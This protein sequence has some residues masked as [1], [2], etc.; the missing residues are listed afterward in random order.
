MKRKLLVLVLGISLFVLL[1][2]SFALAG[3]YGEPDTVWLEKIQTVNP[4]SQVVYRIYLFND[5]NISAFTIP[6]TFPDT[7]SNMDISLDSVSSVGTRIALAQGKNDPSFFPTDSTNVV[8]KNRIALWMVWSWVGAG[9][10]SPVTRTQ[11][12]ATPVVKIYFRTGPSWV[13]PNYVSVDTT[14][15]VSGS[16][17]ETDSVGVEFV[18]KLA[19]KG[20]LDVTDIT[21]PNLPMVFSLSQNY[22][23]PFNPS[24]TI[25]F[26]LPKDDEVTLMIYNVLGQ[27]V[28]ALIDH[29]D[30]PAG[31]KQVE[32]NGTDANN[33]PVASGTYFYQITTENN[34]ITKKMVLTK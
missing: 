34:R 30:L 33:N 9:Y 27:K 8:N 31:T 25:R 20:A 24:T 22:P 16:L 23:N 29:Q 5:H 14:T 17:L 13:S 11:A 28:K 12:L 6:I 1:G 4:N 32:W 21:T 3:D 26:T 7:T 10:L 18:P 15:M 2:L 19:G